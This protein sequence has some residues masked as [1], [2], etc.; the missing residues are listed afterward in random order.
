MSDII[1]AVA[2]QV[3]EKR[4]VLLCRCFFWLARWHFRFELELLWLL[5]FKVKKTPISTILILSN[6][7][8]Q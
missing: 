8:I 3:K 4:T 7:V 1:L 2:A 5:K 6:S